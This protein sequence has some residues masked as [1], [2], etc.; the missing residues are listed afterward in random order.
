[1]ANGNNP[2]G[3][4]DVSGLTAMLNSLVKLTPD[5]HAGAVQNM[6]LSP[7]LF[8]NG[9]KLADSILKAYFASGGTQAMVSVVSRGDLE[10]AMVH[11]EEY[12]NL[13]IRVGGFSARFV[14]LE[15]AVQLE[16][17]SRTLY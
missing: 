16:I 9:G 2:M 6:K 14:E 4:C 11:P 3:G 12:G 10:R 5:L 13:F 17:L 8:Q 1:M 15:R 7:E